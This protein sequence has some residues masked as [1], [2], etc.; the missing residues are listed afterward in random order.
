MTYDLNKMLKRAEKILDKD[1]KIITELQVYGRLGVSQDYWSGVMKKS[2]KFDIIDA[3]M[4]ANRAKG[5]TCVSDKL[6]ESVEAGNVRAMELYGRIVDKEMKEAWT[7]RGR[8]P[9]NT[10]DESQTMPL[11]ELKASIRKL[12][13]QNGFH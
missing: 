5:S 3:K 1:P 11:E 4:H 8:D 12:I 2:S 10:E 9:E 7:Y 6:H 13:D